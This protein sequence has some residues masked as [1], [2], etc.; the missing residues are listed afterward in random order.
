D[1]PALAGDVEADL[2]VVGGGC[3]GLSAALHAAQRGLKVVLLEGGK[4]GWGASGRNGGQMIPGLRKGAVGLVKAFGQ[5][6][7]KALFDLAF[8]ARGLVLD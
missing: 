5:E 8:E 6:R 4:I 7:A 1:H 3:T 2:V